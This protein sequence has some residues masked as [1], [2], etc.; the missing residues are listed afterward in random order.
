MLRQRRVPGQ[1]GGQVADRAGYTDGAVSS[2][3][4]SKEDLFFAVYERRVEGARPRCYRTRG[5]RRGTGVSTGW[6]QPPLSGAA[7]TTAGWRSSLVLAHVLRHLELRE[8]FA[9]VHAR[10]LELVTQTVRQLAEDRGL[11]LPTDVTAGSARPGLER[12]WRSGWG[13]SG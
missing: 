6:P 7:A 8:R 1:L 13:W 4:A 9:A 12:R 2:N 5:G 11:A 10:F 3:F